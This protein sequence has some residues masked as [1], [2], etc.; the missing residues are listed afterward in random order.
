MESVERE[1]ASLPSD[2]VVDDP[3]DE[4]T[5][6]LYATVFLNAD[7]GLSSRLVILYRDQVDILV[8]SD[9]IID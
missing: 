3:L 1:V 2:K 4:L 8:F 6:V 9:L 7:V 5:R